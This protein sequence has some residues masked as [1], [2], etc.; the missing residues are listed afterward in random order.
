MD[1]DWNE[2]NK[3]V[4]SNTQTDTPGTPTA[5]KSVF[6][7]MK[8]GFHHLRLVP[9][10]N[11]LKRTYFL[12]IMQHPI[13]VPRDDGQGYMD[14]FVLCWSFLLT[15]LK[16]YSDPNDQKTKTYISHLGSQKLLNQAEFTAYNTYGCP[17]CK[18]FNHLNN[19]GVDQE[20]K[21]KFYPKEQFFFN[22][23][24][25]SRT[26]SGMP[27]SGDDN[28]Y[29]WRNAKTAGNKLNK[30]IN[31]MR[32]EAGINYLDINTGRDILL[33]ATGEK[34]ARRYPVN[35]FVDTG[36]PLNLGEK[37][38]HNLLDVVNT[39]FKEYQKVVNYIKATYGELLRNNNYLIPGDTALTQAYG[40]AA[41]TVN[42]HIAQIQTPSQVIVQP[43][44]HPYPQAVVAPP[45]P[46]NFGDGS[47]MVGNVQQ[48]APQPTQQFN[49]S[50]NQ[51]EGTFVKDGVL[52]NAL[53][54]QPMF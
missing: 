54:G 52:Y 50:Y 29:I 45:T 51:G 43:P 27:A 18:I 2:V 22:V 4:S 49:P 3:S 32:N 10:G 15:D 16:S 26:F 53:T 5:E 33:E 31:T 13:K 38:P 36:S 46:P 7:R 35:Q 9:A 6:M 34:L 40:Q 21:N 28:V 41:Q 19:M 11:P 44:A 8:A 48:P 23:I 20:T 24:W 39:S 1:I 47:G 42:S 25:R 14:Q 12:Q 37:I 17:F 30:T